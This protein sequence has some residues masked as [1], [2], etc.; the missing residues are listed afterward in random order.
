ML[1][2]AQKP[3]K[4]A[5]WELQKGSLSFSVDQIVLTHNLTLSH[6]GNMLITINSWFKSIKWFFAVKSCFVDFRALV[7]TGGLSLKNRKMGVETWVVSPNEI[8]LQLVTFKEAQQ[9]L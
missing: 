9:L 7:M 8:P 5:L 4:K 3:W 6:Y 1:P 2:N